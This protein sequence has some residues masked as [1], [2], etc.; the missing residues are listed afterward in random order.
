[1][2]SFF[3]AEGSA[4]PPLLVDVRRILLTHALAFFYNEKKTCKVLPRVF[5]CLV[6]EPAEVRTPVLMD[7][8]H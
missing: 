7:L 1:M 6:L 2:P 5:F 8:M 3:C 4:L